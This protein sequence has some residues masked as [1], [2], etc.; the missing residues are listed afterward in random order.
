MASTA[1]RLKAEIARRLEALVRVG[2]GY[3]ALDPASPTLS[4]GESRRVRLAVALTSC[5]EDIVHVL[6]EPTI[7]QHPAD[8][9]RLLPAFRDL[10]GPVIYVEH[11]R[12][13]AA[14]A[15]HVLDLGPGAGPYGGQ[16]TYAGTPAGLWEADTPTGRYFSLRERVVTPERRPAPQTFLTLRRANLRNLRAVDVTIPLER[17]TV[18]TGV[19]GSGKSTLVEDVL[20]ASLQKQAPVGCEAIEGPPLAGVMVDQSPI[21]R[22]PRS[23]P[24][25]YTKL[26]DIVRDLFA[27][28]TGL[29]AS[30]FSFN[31][32][33]GACP[34]C[35][36]LGAVEVAM[37]YLPSTWIPCAAC[38]GETLQRRGPGCNGAL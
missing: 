6:D 7:G 13:A 8:V 19:S 11:D 3:V 10:G 31:R 22:N 24:A 36:G 20:A 2:L 30:H 35:Q 38:G 29:S 33:E 37:R 14:V 4:R 18:V 9:A 12:V 27:E 16:V 34:A 1:A 5:L 15:D 28:A 23:N 32:P 21:G 26:A 25:T 17:L